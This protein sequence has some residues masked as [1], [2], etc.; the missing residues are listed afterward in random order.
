[1]QITAVAGHGTARGY[2]K[3]QDALN[4]NLENF[5]SVSIDTANNR[6]TVGGGVTF[7]DVTTALYEAGKELRASISDVSCPNPLRGIKQLNLTFA[8]RDRKY[9]LRRTG[10]CDHWW[11]HRCNAGPP[12]SEPRF[13][14]VRPYRDSIGGR[15][16]RFTD[17]EL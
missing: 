14:L 15:R 5:K 2:A 9:R 13:A 6:L 16:D 10:R 8:F 4:I 1:M 3:Y 7:G 17:A 12:W 11:R